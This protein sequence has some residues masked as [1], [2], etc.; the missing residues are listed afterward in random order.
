MSDLTV[1]SNFHCQRYFYLTISKIEF[2]GERSS[3]LSGQEVFVI[4][5]LAAGL[6]F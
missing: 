5:K 2:S 1:I 3:T 4:R 6:Y